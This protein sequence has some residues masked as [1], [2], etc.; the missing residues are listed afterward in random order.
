MYGASADRC[1]GLEF[2]Q[3]ACSWS[4]RLL[5]CIAGQDLLSADQA[6]VVKAAKKKQKGGKKAATKGAKAASGST[7][8]AEDDMTV[9]FFVA[10]PDSLQEEEWEPQGLMSVSSTASALVA[11]T[12]SQWSSCSSCKTVRSTNWCFQAGM[13]TATCTSLP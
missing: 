12:S 13:L 8:H 10:A 7:A 9:E 4:T 2:W 1:L 3:S 6:H 11:F 5:P